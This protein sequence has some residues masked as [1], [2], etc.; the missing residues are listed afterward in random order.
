MG[1]AP[2]IDEPRLMDPRI[3]W[4]KPM[5]LGSVLLDLRLSD[6]LSYDP[7]RNVLFANFEGYAIR[8]PDDVDSVRRVFEALCGRIGRPVHLVANYDGFVID[9]W[10]LDRYVDMVT[11]LQA[12][13]YASATRYTTSAFIRLKLGAALG[14][15]DAAAHIFETRAEAHDFLVHQGGIGLDVD[16]PP[17]SI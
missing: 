16:E 1:F 9:D 15:R 6:R 8:T 10:V 12:R 5:G 7:A 14:A 3:F 17:S 2:R 11:E 4:Q 13:F